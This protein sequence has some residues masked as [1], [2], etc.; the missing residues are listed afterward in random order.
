MSS[1]HADERGY[2]YT[3]RY[4]D[5]MTE[6]MV[7]ERRARKRESA[8]EDATAAAA[9][10][11]AAAPEAPP[12]DAARDAASASDGGAAADERVVPRF[13]VGARIAARRPLRQWLAI[14]NWCPS[15]WVEPLPLADVGGLLQQSNDDAGTYQSVRLQPRPLLAALAPP[16]LPEEESSSEDDADDVGWWARLQ[17]P[18]AAARSAAAA[19]AARATRG[20]R[21]APPPPTPALIMGVH[22]DRERKLVDHLPE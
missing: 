12:V 7:A 6:G 1:V 9:A 15:T 16:A 14:S 4:A 18:S 10:A 22:C 17:G 19:K 2:S 11:A 20:K 21:V 3:L 5:G 13:G 8:V